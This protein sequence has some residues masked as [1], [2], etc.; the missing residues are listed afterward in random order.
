V[1]CISIGMLN[2]SSCSKS[3]LN[4]KTQT[5]VSSKMHVWW[6][7]SGRLKYSYR[8]CRG[9]VQ[10]TQKMYTFFIS[11]F[12]PLYCLRHVSNNQVFILRKTFTCSFMIFYH[13]S[14]KAVCPLAGCL[15]YHTHPAI[16]QTAFI[17]AWKKYHKT[18]CKSLPEDEHLVVRNM[19]EKI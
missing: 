18:A 9:Y 17:D 2:W 14:I 12:I 3:K 7:M 13:A 16:D 6:D 8:R 4:R 10:R 19:S 1:I 15:W 11:D 5:C